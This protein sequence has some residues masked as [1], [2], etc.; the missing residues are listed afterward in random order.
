[1]LAKIYR[2]AKSAMQSG[3]AATRRWVLEFEP[4]TALG[5]DQLMG[6]TSSTDTNGQVRI[7]FDTLELAIAFAR[8]RSIP[9]QVTEP[10][11]PK[12]NLRTYSDNF[13]FSRREPW[14][15]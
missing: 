5:Q 10:R 6:W 13:A 8:A 15:H 1:M 3:K 4:G 2:P 12:P 9:H 11:Q 14:S 7:Y